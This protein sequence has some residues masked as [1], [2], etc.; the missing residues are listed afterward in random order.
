MP[1][2]A[3][4]R[5]ALPTVD[6]EPTV[7]DEDF[8]AIRW[9]VLGFG[10]VAVDDLL[11]VDHYPS[12]DSKMQVKAKRR[13]GGGLT[14]TALVAAARLGVRAAYAGVLGDDELSRFTIEAL[15]RAGVDCTPVVYRA[16]ARPYHSIIIVDQSTGSRTIL[17]SAD[18]VVKRRPDEVTEELIANCRVLFVD[19]L[20]AKA[21]LRA[22]ELAHTR[23]I[24]VVGDFEQQTLSEVKEL[25]PQVDHLIISLDLARRMTGEAEPSRM[26]QALSSPERACCGVTAGERGCWYSEQGGEVR[27]FPA[28]RVQ[29]VDTTGCGDVFHGA[30]AA[31]LARGESVGRAIQIATATAG[32][33]ATQPGGRTGIPDWATVERFLKENPLQINKGE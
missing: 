24:P 27:Y 3:R 9:D 25:M 22:V 1:W 16:E 28:Y 5:A 33:K 13:E 17:F 12:P 14:A 18:G 30:Y 8:M 7:N 21:G 20:E 15:E 19:H 29:V 10:T 4:H 6:D 32:L 26:V 2:R 11:Y 31:C 23:G